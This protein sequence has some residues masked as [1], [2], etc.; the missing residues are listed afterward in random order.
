MLLGEG[1]DITVVEP[2]STSHLPWDITSRQS[3]VSVDVGVFTTRNFIFKGHSVNWNY[4][5]LVT[6]ESNSRIC[7]CI[8]WSTLRIVSMFNSMTLNSCFWF[9]PFWF[10]RVHVNFYINPIFPLQTMYQSRQIKIKEKE[11]SILMNR[12]YFVNTYKMG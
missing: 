5:I 10:N 1:V 8:I 9:N 11:K 12:D 3:L 6:C 2:E 7:L 4:L